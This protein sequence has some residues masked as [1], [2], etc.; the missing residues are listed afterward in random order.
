MSDQPTPL[1]DSVEY[2]PGSETSAYVVDVDF[3]RDLERQLADTRQ[4]NYEKS[5][6]LDHIADE[7]DLS[8]DTTDDDIH[9]AVIQS[10][11]QAAPP[12]TPVDVPRLLALLKTARQHSAGMK[13]DAYDAIQKAINELEPNQP[14]DH[15]R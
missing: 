3:A 14:N 10:I 5:C 8:S 13:I 11:Q 4:L 7:L 12:A 15:P 9:F 6:V 1:T 2:Q